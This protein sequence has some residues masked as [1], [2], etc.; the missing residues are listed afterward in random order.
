[1]LAV[2]RNNVKLLRINLPLGLSLLLPLLISSVFYAS[3]KAFSFGLLLLLVC[4][5]TRRASLSS[6]EDAQNLV[7][8]NKL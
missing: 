3:H 8:S 1:M 4:A 5:I 6:V 7:Y 2:L